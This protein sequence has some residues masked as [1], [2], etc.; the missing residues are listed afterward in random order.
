[1]KRCFSLFI[2]GGIG[3]SLLEIL[4]RGYTHPSMTVLGGIC[5]VG[6]DWINKRFK[7][8][9]KALRALCCAGFITVAEFLSG[10][11]LNRWLKLG[12]WDYSNLKLHI[13]G[14]VSLLFSVLWFCISYLA[15]FLLDVS[16]RNREKRAC[17]F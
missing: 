6:I 1:M 11:L 9:T 3:Y 13:M 12:V 8:C 16:A 4:W 7:Q 17:R 15:I 10:L 2:I 5:F 14:Q